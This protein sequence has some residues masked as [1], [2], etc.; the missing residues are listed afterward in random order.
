MTGQ[1]AHP[2]V[3][4]RDAVPGDLA[5]I[6]DIYAHHVQHGLAS[7]EETP[8]DLA[9]LTRRYEA[10]LA[11]GFP[12]LAAETEGFGGAGAVQGYAY[13]GPYRPRP[14]YRYTVENSVYVAPDCQARGVGRALLAELIQRCAALG[15]RQMI[16]VIG[17]SDHIAS[18][19]FHESFG[20][21]RCGDIRSVGFK[22]GRWVDS[23][24]LQL[25]LGKGDTTL[26][27][28]G[29]PDRESPSERPGGG[30]A[31]TPTQ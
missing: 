10:I 25:P 29:D 12:Y 22:F 20:F 5:R 13:A 18:I 11:G 31:E 14:A 23:V 2:A 24:I 6:H 16:A 27:D 4:V 26:P 8:P 17:D 15:Y 3:R 19:R 30:S 21:A 28:E 7:F 9:E 1:D